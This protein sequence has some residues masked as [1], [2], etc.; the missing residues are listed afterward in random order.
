MCPVCHV[1]SATK[2]PTTP[3]KTSNQYCTT[4]QNDYLYVFRAITI[5]PPTTPWNTGRRLVCLADTSNGCEIHFRVWQITRII[6][7]RSNTRSVT[8]GPENRGKHELLNKC[9]GIT[10][11]GYG[12]DHAACRLGRTRVSEIGTWVSWHNISNN[13]VKVPN[14]PTEELCLVLTRYQ[15]GSSRSICFHRANT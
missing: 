15:Y 10:I 3:P 11:W 2:N 9:F 1:M 8:N 6:R 14:V 4:W 13:H 5:S 7:R 12:I